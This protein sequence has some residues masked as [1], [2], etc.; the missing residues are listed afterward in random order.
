MRKMK[1]LRML[2]VAAMLLGMFSATAFASQI[3][4][5]KNAELN[6][7]TGTNQ[8]YPGDTIYYTMTVSNPED[9]PATNT[10]T[11]IWDTL[12]D[13]TVIE[14][15]DPGDTLVQE[16]GDSATF[17]AEYV[18]DWDNAVPGAAPGTYIVRNKFEAEGYD[19][20]TTPDE[21]Y[22]LVT[23]N[24]EVLPLLSLGDFVWNDDNRNG[25]QDVGEFGI[26]SVTVNLWSAVDGSPFAVLA[27]TTTD[28]LGGYLFDGLRADEYFVEFV[29]PAGDWAFTL[30]HVGDDALDSDANPTTGISHLI[31][32]TADDMTV[33]AGLYELDY[34]LTVSK[35]VFTHYTREHEWGIDKWITTEEGDTI[36]FQD[37]WI[38]KIW[39]T[40]D[41]NPDETAT[42]HVKVTYVGYE[43]MDFNVFGSV[44]I[45]NTG[46]V[47][48][49][50]TSVEDLLAGEL[51]TVD[52]G[53]TFPHVLPAGETLVGW[54]DEDVQSMVTGT[55]DVT[56]TDAR[57][58][59]YNDS[60]VITWGEPYEEEL[61]EVHIEDD[62]DLN[63][64]V[65]LGTL[66]AADFTAGGFHTF[67]YNEN[68]A[69]TDYTTP[70]PHM[71]YNTAEI[72]ETGQIASAVLDVN[73]VGNEE[74]LVTKTAVPTYTRTHEWDIDKWVETEN[75]ETVDDGMTP[76]IW[77]YDD[78][79]GDETATWYV[80]VT[81]K[82]Y[83]DSDFVV[84]GTITITN[85]GTVAT[86]ILDVEDFIDGMPISVV[87]PALP[88]T[89][90]VG[91]S[92]AFTYS[93]DLLDMTAE[94]NTATVTTDETTYGGFAAIPWG[95]PTREVDAVVDIVDLSTEFGSTD[96]GTLDAA[97]LAVDEVTTFDYDHFFAWADYDYPE[98]HEIVIENT[99]T[100][101]QTGQ[102][103]S[104]ILKVN[105]IPREDYEGLTPGFWKN[106]TDLWIGYEP[107]QLVGDVFDIPAALNELA[108]DTLLEALNYGG[109]KGAVGAARSLLRAAVAA[110]LNSEHP[111]I[112]YSA[113]T[114]DI[115]ADV[116][117]AL[118]SMDKDEMN[119]LKDELDMWN[120]MGGGIDAHGNPY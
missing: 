73:W 94:M 24:S 37:E 43:D 91:E 8:F 80:D 92:V 116:N 120:N 101:V 63:G 111:E 9:N 67:T 69:Y 7:D 38:P 16:P 118:A 34:E 115:I 26:E 58:L 85:T 11:R 110:L 81:Y 27:T 23:R 29:K 89:L 36:L 106:H 114:A 71:Y 56:V 112:T 54:Y 98:H 97:L 68:F 5:T 65:Q 33:D 95:D 108:D 46:E 57:Q 86:E 39:L 117:A 59:T 82:G 78:G 19:N 99:A 12:P 96:L 25:I 61:D 107:E 74:L 40:H 21:V 52:F 48:A 72:V 90:A 66:Y 60:E 35:T 119:M 105:W 79:T 77:L 47:D 103:A 102:N 31:N 41:D 10:L 30:Q 83:T 32:L 13:G 88:L 104:A 3:A 75:G 51:I 49:T 70:G 76:K 62:S 50:I 44:T 93:A 22:A 109:G 55:N 84:S 6:P 1:W 15:L 87:G 2:L 100:I 45:T 18:V 20:A 53:V 42:W 113:T 4:A 64:L 14:F 28:A 17:Y